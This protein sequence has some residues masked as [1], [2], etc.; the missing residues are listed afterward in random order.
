MA[1]FVISDIAPKVYMDGYYEEWKGRTKGNVVW[2][3][4]RT[5]AAKRWVNRGLR[6]RDG[7]APKPYQKRWIIRRWAK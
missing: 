5:R 2:F 1:E 7:V 6:F 3:P 4:I